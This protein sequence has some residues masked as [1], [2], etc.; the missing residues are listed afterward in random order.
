MMENSSGLKP[1]EAAGV[2]RRAVLSGAL[3]LTAGAASLSMPNIARAAVKSLKI[4]FIAPLSGIRSAFAEI[5]LVHDRA[6][7]KDAQGRARHPR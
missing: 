5:D 3:A 1:I 4:G 2:S 7:A 6:G